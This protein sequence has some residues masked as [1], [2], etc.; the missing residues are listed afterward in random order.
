MPSAKAVNLRGASHR[1]IP[2]SAPTVPAHTPPAMTTVLHG[3][4]CNS[5]SKRG[6]WQAKCHSSGAMGKHAAKPNRAV[7]TPHHWHRE[8]G[9][10]ADIVQVSTEETPPCDELFA[11]TVDCGS[12]GDIEEIVIDDIHTPRCNEAYTTVKLH[13]SISS[14][15]T[16]SLCV[17]VNTGAGGNVLPLHVF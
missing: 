16:A 11:D 9:K 6:H 17:N 8:K 15:G 5:C 2:H 12:A 10:T 4:T 14:K 7:K 13:A 3:A 1:R